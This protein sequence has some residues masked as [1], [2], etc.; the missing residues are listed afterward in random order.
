[1]EELKVAKSMNTG[2]YLYPVHARCISPTFP[3]ARSSQTAPPV[4][5]MTPSH[6]PNSRY[7]RLNKFL[8][9]AVNGTQQVTKQTYKL[10]IESIHSQPDAAACLD[11]LISSPKGLTNLQ[12]SMNIDSS[13]E[14]FNGSANSFLQYISPREVESLVG[15]E[16]L[17]RI[18]LA[19]TEPPDFWHGFKKRFVHRELSNT[20]L[21]SFTWLFHHLVHLPG[22][23]SE[24]YHQDARDSKILGPLLDSP[25]H[26][27]KTTA[28]MIRHHISIPPDHDGPGGRHSND[29]ADFRSIDILPTP[30]E[31]ASDRPS[32]LP[33]RAAVE[34]C[35]SSSSRSESH[36]D[37]QFRLLRDDML[38][39]MRREVPPRAKGRSDPGT[40]SVGL[41]FAGVYHGSDE[42]P[43][44]WGVKCE[45]GP[46]ARK[47]YLGETFQHGS[48][49]C[50]VLDDHFAAFPLLHLDK[51][52]VL[53]DPPIIVLQLDDPKSVST[54]L[55]GFIN[56]KRIELFPLHDAL[57][58][59]GPVLSALK[60]ASLPYSFPGLFL[61]TTIPDTKQSCG[62]HADLID[63]ITSHC[64]QNLQSFLQTPQ[65]IILDKAQT[66]ALVNG[67][68][69]R[70]SL[71]QCPPGTSSIQH[72]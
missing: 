6:S 4:L 32:Y 27:I 66:D 26:S 24:P 68:S 18:L 57:F 5:I 48:T 7:T 55:S 8:D 16:R 46:G 43:R 14:F 69:H 12:A 53:Q 49:T 11:K 25:V 3:L 64:R 1:M 71:I 58:A 30:D 42:D 23:A 65:S 61:E 10:F 62:L 70:L 29:F 72:S 47:E 50:L 19:I 36:L 40:S 28:Q 52:L 21:Q 63:K 13:S 38:F 54:V 22:G 15:V 33:T 45:V 2:S 51:E 20:A 9:A 37:I 41:R 31:L 67:L 39:E 17:R 44:R 59:H 34:A 35:G 56:S 60:Q